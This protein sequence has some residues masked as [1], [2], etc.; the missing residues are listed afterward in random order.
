[1][2][3][4]VVLA[5]GLHAFNCEGTDDYTKSKLL[6]GSCASPISATVYSAANGCFSVSNDG[7]GTY[8]YEIMQCDS[9]GASLSVYGSVLPFCN[10]NSL[11]TV[12]VNETFISTTCTSFITS[13]TTTVYAQLLDC[14]YDG[15]SNFPVMQD[16]SDDIAGGM[17][18]YMGIGVNIFAMAADTD[19]TD[20]DLCGY[21]WY[22]AFEA[23]FTNSLVEVTTTCI[24]YEGVGYPSVTVN[25]TVTVYD[26]ADFMDCETIETM[27]LNY[28]DNTT[29]DG[30]IS[31]WNY[32]IAYTTP[33]PTMAVTPSPTNGSGILTINYLIVLAISFFIMMM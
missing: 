22:E 3:D 28:I 32:T 10:I 9:T 18:P 25:G 14:V 30:S 6:A 5:T 24:S 33:S 17:I 8:G 19:T 7:N 4:D 11:Y 26:Q 15:Y 1:M 21:D 23:I 12:L 16:N 31:C 13:G 2:E 29:T 27:F 20:P